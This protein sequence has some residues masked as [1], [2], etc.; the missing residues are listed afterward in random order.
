MLSVVTPWSYA[1]VS[2]CCETF[3]HSSFGLNDPQSKTTALSEHIVP[4]GNSATANFLN[5]DSLLLHCLKYGDYVRSIPAPHSQPPQCDF[6]VYADNKR[7]FHLIELKVTSSFGTRIRQL[8]DSLRSLLAIAGVK[9]FVDGFQSKR[10]CYFRKTPP[11]PIQTLKAI[12]AFNRS[13]TLIPRNGKKIT[14][15]QQTSDIVRHG[16]ELWHFSDTDVCQLV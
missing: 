5:P 11:S 1:T 16:F 3:D 13:R 10:C 2:H 15:T 6:I 12:P 4:N 9:D 14:N 7:C 8:R